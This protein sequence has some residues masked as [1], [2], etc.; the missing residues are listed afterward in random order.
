MDRDKRRI[1]HLWCASGH[2][3]LNFTGYLA[4]NFEIRVGGSEDLGNN[5]ICH[6]QF[7]FMDS[8]NTTIKC[9][10]PLLGN[11]VSIN[12]TDTEFA[13]E[14]LGFREVRVFGRKCV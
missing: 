4:Y 6:K 11:W 2:N 1:K 14:Y 7:Y 12:S 5:D 9:S 8:L 10:R 3:G 13:Y